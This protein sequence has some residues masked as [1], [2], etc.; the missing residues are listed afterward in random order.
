MKTAIIYYSF[1]G[2]TRKLAQQKAKELS[3]DIFEVKERIK[4]NTFTALLFG[5]PLSLNRKTVKIEPLN[6]DFSLY[7][8]FIV[9]SPVW[10]G[11]PA[12]AFNSILELLPKGKVVDVVLCSAGGQTPDSKE[13]TIEL[14]AQKGFVEGTYTDIKTDQG[15]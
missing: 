5:C 4:R 7:D 10:A 8:K 11:Y 12:C 14:L 2:S 13:G 6:I 9:F 3:A 15:M 1:K